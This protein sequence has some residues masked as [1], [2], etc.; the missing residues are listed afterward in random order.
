MIDVARYAV[1]AESGAF[2]EVTT[3]IHRLARKPKTRA[4]LPLHQSNINLTTCAET[5]LE[6]ECFP[7]SQ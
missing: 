5:R 1:A 3:A 2:D 6:M 7:L 4:I